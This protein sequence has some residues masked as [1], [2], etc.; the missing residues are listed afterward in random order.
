MAKAKER[1]FICTSCLHVGPGRVHYLRLAADLFLNA[2]LQM[3]F[4]TPFF[5]NVRSCEVCDRWTLAA[6]DS[7]KGQEALEARQRKL[8]KARSAPSRHER[9]RHAR[10]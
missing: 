9:S 4:P 3:L 6:L 7:P 8:E 1:E 5:D 2:V 10:S